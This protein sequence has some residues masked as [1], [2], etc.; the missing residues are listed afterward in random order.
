M[1]VP[2]KYEYSKLIRSR[3]SHGCYRELSYE[4]RK[5]L[6]ILFRSIIDGECNSEQ[7]RK[8][9]NSSPDFSSYENFELV[10]GKI[11]TCILKNDV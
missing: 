10:K 7:K 9:L 6:T 3:L 1:V 5:S 2:K 11:K 4:S 8:I